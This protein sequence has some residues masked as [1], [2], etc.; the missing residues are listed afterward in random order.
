MFYLAGADPYREDQLGSLGLTI[1]GLTRRE[2]FV[3]EAAGKSRVPLVITL[4]G[5]YARNTD[6]TVEIHC[7]TCGSRSVDFDPDQIRARFMAIAHSSV[8]KGSARWTSSD[9]V[10]ASM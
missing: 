4:A 8:E 7:N 2:A 9:F 5:G 6:D 3:I 1:D 10:V